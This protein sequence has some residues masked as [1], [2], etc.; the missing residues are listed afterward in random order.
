ME[1]QQCKMTAVDGFK[2]LELKPIR[3]SSGLK[4]EE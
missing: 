1:R 4:C 2:I 3:L